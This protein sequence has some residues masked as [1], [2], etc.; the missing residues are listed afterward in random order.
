MIRKAFIMS[1]NPGQ[2]EEYTR[3]HSPIWPELEATLKSHG[4][5]NY[6]IFL[7]KETS[8]LFAY[9]EIEDEAR[10]AAIAATPICR[11]W[12]AHMQDLMPSN[13]DNSPIST[14]LPQ[15]FHID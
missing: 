13:P 12:W 10:W 6:S 2:E 11:K 4:V 8:Q 3:R 1:V 7:N 15:V 9:V 14:E 5:H